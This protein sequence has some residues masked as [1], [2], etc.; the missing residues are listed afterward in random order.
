MLRLNLIS[1]DIRN[2]KETTTSVKECDKIIEG[3]KK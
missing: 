2:F 3:E 1:Y